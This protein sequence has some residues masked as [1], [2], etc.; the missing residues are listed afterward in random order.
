VFLID[1]NIKFGYQKHM[2]MRLPTFQTLIL[3]LF[4]A[5]GITLSGCSSLKTEPKGA[6]D[7]P[8]GLIR[9]CCTTNIV[10]DVVQQVGGDHVCVTA[11]MDGPGIDPHLYAPSPQDINLLT[12]SQVVVY[13]GLHL[14][15]QM[16][17]TLE[18]L[19]NRGIRAIA[20]TSILSDDHSKRLLHVGQAI[21]PHVWFDFELW[22]LCAESL[23]E[24]LA[25]IDPDHADDYRANAHEYREHLK[26]A[27]EEYVKLLADVPDEQ[28]VLVTAHDAFQYFARRFSFEV[29]AIQGL[30]T[31]S[32]PGLKRIN[33][34]AKTLRDRRIGSI[35]TEQSVSDRS[36]AALIA[37]CASEGHTVTIGGRLFSD[38]AGAAGTPEESLTGAT[39]HNVREI[40]AALKP[41]VTES[42]NSD[43]QG[44]P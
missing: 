18:S 24:Q 14:E 21:D 10:K 29:E 35:F 37:A 36:I 19:Q 13:A 11:M 42:I 9:I 39:L 33:A 17:D 6:T 27:Q 31:E 1:Q 3:T 2:K 44:T 7:C 26:A 4:L 25:D 23:G 34:L 15:A 28:R 12:A 22:G 38:T 41:S 32:E 30:S 16:D 5:A 40:A 20:L 8:D 43:R